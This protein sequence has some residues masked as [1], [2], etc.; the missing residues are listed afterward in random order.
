MYVLAGIKQ[1]RKN[2][3]ELK[4]NPQSQTQDAFVRDEYLRLVKRNGFLISS[5]YNKLFWG[6]FLIFNIL[7]WQYFRD[8]W[9][10]SDYQHKE[11]R[12]YYALGHMLLSYEMGILVFTRDPG[13][14]VMKP[15]ALLQ[16]SLVNSAK[17]VLPKDD[18]EIG[19]FKFHLLLY[20][21]ASR[22]YA[23][24][25]R[26]G[27]YINALTYEVLEDLSTK[28]MEDPKVNE[29]D[30]FIYH[31]MAL[32]YYALVFSNKYGE[33]RG[34][35]TQYAY[36]K[37]K[38]QFNKTKALVQWTIDAHNEWKTYS[39]INA[40]MD[41]EPKMV[42]IHYSLIVH[43]LDRILWYKIMNLQ[44]RCEDKH[45]ALYQKYHYF[46][47]EKYQPY[48]TDK[49]LNADGF[50]NESQKLAIDTTYMVSGMAHY[51]CGYPKMISWGMYFDAKTIGYERKNG[52]K[53]TFPFFERFLELDQIINKGEAIRKGEAVIEPCSGPRCHSYD[54]L[55]T[56]IE[57][58]K[59]RLY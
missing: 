15:I 26:E 46:Y 56:I 59:M 29:Y 7:F 23:P 31:T 44:F 39:E 53:H 35:Y 9:V 57:N 3:R 33:K 19:I 38:E 43:F 24:N 1:W 21:Y 42:V 55:K 36:F 34:P 18:G 52:F 22:F 4:A 16:E 47:K 13:I 25:A 5:K 27:K 48:Y 58:D 12:E 28:K 10:D 45:L 51:L 37:D 6:L 49:R 20:P 32:Q 40:F 41:N 30:K 8:K 11:A 2:K 17:K 50:Y 54:E 14:Y